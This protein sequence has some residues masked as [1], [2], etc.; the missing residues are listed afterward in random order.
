MPNRATPS[1]NYPNDSELT[2]DN[3]PK[4]H[5]RARTY[6]DLLRDIIFIYQALTRLDVV[7]N[8]L[9]D[10]TM[11]TDWKDEWPNLR[12]FQLVDAIEVCR[13]ALGHCYGDAYAS[14]WAEDARRQGDDIIEDLIDGDEH[15][16]GPGTLP[17]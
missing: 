9:R 10:F 1:L 8:P 12:D 13:S 5:M 6:T 11:T 2:S 15:R 3:C 16:E 7:L 17:W 4:Y 14:L